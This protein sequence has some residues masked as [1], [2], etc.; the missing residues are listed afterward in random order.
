MQHLSAEQRALIIEALRDQ[1]TALRA[2][3]AALTDREALQGTKDKIA[4]LQKTRQII[5]NSSSIDVC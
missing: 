4:E 3:F 2:R 1:Q 5:E